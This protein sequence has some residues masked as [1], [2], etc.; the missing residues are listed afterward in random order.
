MTEI[1][2]CVGVFILVLALYLSYSQTRRIYKEQNELIESLRGESRFLLK[3]HRRDIELL[4]WADEAGHYDARFESI[5][6]ELRSA[7]EKDNAKT[8]R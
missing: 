8:T 1:I 5:R 6:E 7:M 4:D 2:F 3:E